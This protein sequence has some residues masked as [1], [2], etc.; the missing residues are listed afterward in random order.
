MQVNLVEVECV[1]SVVQALEKAAKAFNA[2][3]AESGGTGREGLS[4]GIIT[5]YNDQVAMVDHGSEPPCT[6]GNCG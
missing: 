3:A 2:A 5:P 1:V 4:V 6:M